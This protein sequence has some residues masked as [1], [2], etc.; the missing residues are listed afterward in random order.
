MVFGK[1]LFQ[2][3]ILVNTFS[4]YIPEKETK[5]RA[6]GFAANFQGALRKAGIPDIKV[7]AQS[8]N[9]VEEYKGILGIPA[10]FKKDDP[11]VNSR[12]ETNTSSRATRRQC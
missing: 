3:C 8:T 11:I 7:Q 2:H 5:E 12:L 10:G 4:N 1:D 9:P 6:K